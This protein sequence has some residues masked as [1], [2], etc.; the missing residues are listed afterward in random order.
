MALRLLD[1]PCCLGDGFRVSLTLTRNDDPSRPARG[2]GRLARNDG[3]LRESCTK[4][5]KRM[6]AQ[7]Q[8]AG[9]K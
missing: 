2:G 8:L 4:K 3:G 9:K 7:G 1:M 5:G 6:L